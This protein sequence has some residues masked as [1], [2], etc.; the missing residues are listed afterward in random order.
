M[1]TTILVVDDDKQIRTIWSRALDEIGGFS[2][3]V[4]GTAT[5]AL[6]KIRRGEFD[7]ALVDF[8]LPDMDGLQLITEMVTCKPKILT[9]LLTGYGG[10]DSAV[11]A[12][13]RGASDYLTKPVDLDEMIV[14]LRRVLERGS[15]S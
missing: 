1:R 15:A 6:I 13:K 5:E 7:L 12:M 9:V 11:E 10:I 3:E 8:K 4:A 2:V 14:R